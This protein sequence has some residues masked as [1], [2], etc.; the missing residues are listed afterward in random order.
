MIL[1]EVECQSTNVDNDGDDN[2]EVDDEDD[3]DTN[4]D[5]YGTT[6]SGVERKHT[7]KLPVKTNHDT[8]SHQLRPSLLLVMI[9][10]VTGV[11]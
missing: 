5:F 1:N 4:E 7:R 9:V 2:T 10:R 3:D 11:A 8:S 6:R